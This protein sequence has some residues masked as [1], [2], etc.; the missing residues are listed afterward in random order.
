MLIWLPRMSRISASSTLSRSL[1]RNRT[2]PPTMRPGC[3]MSRI[4]DRAVMLLPQPDS[5]TTPTVLPSPISYETPSTA[6]TVPSWV[7]KWVRRSWIS[8]R[9]R[10]DLWTVMPLLPH[11][12]ARVEG[13]PQAVAHETR[14]ED[15]EDQREPGVEDQDGLP[16]EELLGVGE[17][18]AQACLRWRDSEAEERERGFHDHGVGD[19]QGG[20]DDHRRHGRR[21]H[22]AHD[23]APVAGAQCPG[24]LH[25]VRF[26]QREELGA[27][28][29]R[30]G[31][32][33]HDADGHDDHDGVPV[34]KRATIIT[35]RKKLGN[36]RTTSTRRI[37]RLSTA[38]PT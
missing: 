27:H 35:M 10:S 25:E 26:A 7:K 2:E 32:P 5:P 14:R 34:P 18:V 11:P 12:L 17:H 36:D 38:P 13:I 23:D 19:A 9:G 15:D 28:E 30:G 24:R 29:S 21:Q 3:S 1:P 37:R 33:A 8:R 20:G 6:L 22:V 31:R 4:T 16:V